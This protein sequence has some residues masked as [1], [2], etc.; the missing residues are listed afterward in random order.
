MKKIIPLLFVLSA[1]LVNAATIST[2]NSHSCKQVK[3]SEKPFILVLK[4]G[5]DVTT[6]LAQCANDA[7]LAGAS[8]TGIGALENPKLDYFNLETKKYQDKTLNGIYEL[9]SM[10]GNI[11]DVA[12]KRVPHLHVALS[13]SEFQM[14]GGHL[15]SARVGVTAEITITPFRGHVVKS[16]DDETGL[17]L[18]KTLR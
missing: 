10:T 8:L 17:E 5:E 18:I 3:G 9:I 6:A 12:G 16:M 7:K 14:T 1:T 15:G 2:V 4:K 13:D 11:T